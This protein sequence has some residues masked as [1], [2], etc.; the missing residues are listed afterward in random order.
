VLRHAA[1]RLD[2]I[3]VSIEKEPAPFDS[4]ECRNHEQVAA[5]KVR[6]VGQNCLWHGDN[7]DVL[8]S[9]QSD[10][11]DLVYLDPPFK[12][13]Q[14]YNMLYKERDG[15]RS[16]AQEKAFGDTWKWDP[17]AAKAYRQVVEGGGHVSDVMDAFRRILATGPEIREHGRS[18]MLAYL[19]MMAPRLVENAPRS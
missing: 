6:F 10:S 7:L 2:S 17:K 16:A 4:E 15:S 11:V 18:E 8:R 12:S 1:A 9:L 5:K 14:D 19:S 13:N 3:S